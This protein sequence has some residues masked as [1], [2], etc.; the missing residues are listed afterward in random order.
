MGEGG[1]R[2][3]PQW[4]ERG[5]RQRMVEKGLGKRGVR[6]QR[7]EAE[8]ESDQTTYVVFVFLPLCSCSFFKSSRYV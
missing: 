6:K 7:R 2:E 4:M 5:G 3:A 1:G 8:E